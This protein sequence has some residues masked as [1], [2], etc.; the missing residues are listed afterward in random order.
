[1][2]PLNHVM[3]RKYV[4]RSFRSLRPHSSGARLDPPTAACRG[5]KPLGY[6]AKPQTRNPKTVQ[7]NAAGSLRVPLNSV[8]SIPQ[9]WG[10]TGG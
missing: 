6:V 5:A 10:N 3:S 4:A 8:S 2:H 7:R 1:M 9:E